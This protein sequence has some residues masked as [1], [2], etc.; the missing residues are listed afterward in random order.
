MDRLRDIIS[1][2]ETHLEQARIQHSSSEKK[3]NIASKSMTADNNEV[4][5]AILSEE[6]REQMDR[7]YG[8]NGN[9]TH[10]LMPK[11]KKAKVI[12]TV[13][14]T[15][16]EIRQAKKSQKNANRK[17]NQLAA[18]AEQKQRRGIPPCACASKKGAPY[19]CCRTIIT[20][21]NARLPTCPCPP[22]LGNSWGA[23]HPWTDA[24]APPCAPPLQP[25]WLQRPAI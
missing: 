21:N 11:K 8:D 12:R 15:Q 2:S 19:V 18:R 24:P 20:H 5:G 7:G 25:A 23:R 16:T 10:V 22:S 1:I 14:L 6:M 13:E 9:N 3:R 17:L 4:D